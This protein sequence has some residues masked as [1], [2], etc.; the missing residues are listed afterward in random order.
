MKHK[1]TV[2]VVT[3]KK[4]L[5]GTKK[6]REQKTIWVDGKT[7][8]EMQRQ[9]KKETDPGPLTFEEMLLYDEIFDD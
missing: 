4:G 3:E 2:T 7:Y 8:R 6:V 9:K 1:V 5:F